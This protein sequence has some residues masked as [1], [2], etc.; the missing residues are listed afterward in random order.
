MPLTS[1]EAEALRNTFQFIYADL[2]CQYRGLLAVLEQRQVI[3]AAEHIEE[4]VRRWV[5]EHRHSAGDEALDRLQRFFAGQ[6]AD[7]L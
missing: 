3:A 2:W 5:R 6:A 1:G 7:D 4:D